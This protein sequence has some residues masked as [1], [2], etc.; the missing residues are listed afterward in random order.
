MVQ[1]GGLTALIGWGTPVY[2]Q[3]KA[4]LII[5]LQVLRELL[6]YECKNRLLPVAEG[7][8][9]SVKTPELTNY[10][11]TVVEKSGAYSSLYVSFLLV[12]FFST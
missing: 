10:Y 4:M 8:K 5:V 3:K 7:L 9:N 12:L 6:W 11:P 1:T 2:P